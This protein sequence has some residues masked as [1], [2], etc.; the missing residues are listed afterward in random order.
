M[1][2]KFLFFILYVLISQFISVSSSFATPATTNFQAYIA[3]PDGKPLQ[4]ANVNFTLKYTNPT[5][6]CVL[7]AEEFLNRNMQGSSGNVNLRMGEGNIVY[8]G[9]STFYNVFNNAATGINC[10]DGAVSY[11]P[12]LTDIRKLTVIF[13]HPKSNGD[14][15][16]GGIEIES[17]PF[18]MYAGQA[19]TALN[20][21]NFS[22]LL[23]GDITGIQN[24]TSVVK[25]RGVPV[26][27][28]APALG[29]VLQFNGTQYVPVAIPSAPVTSVAGRTGAVVL[30]N[31]DISGLGDAAVKN[32]GTAAGTLAAGNDSRIT[33]AF[34]TASTLAGDL[35]GNLPN[36]TVATVNGKTAAQVAIS[37]DDTIAATNINTVGT[38][39]KR[40]GSGN[41]AVGNITGNNITSTNSSATTFS[42]RNLFL[43]DNTNTNK[44]TLKAPNVF[45]SDY[46]FILPV[47]AGTAGYVLSTDGAGNTNWIVASS[48]SV[49]N[50]T[51]TAPIAST[52]GAAP[53]ISIAT[54]NTST[55]GALTSADWNTFSA[56]QPQG[57][58]ITA[59]TGEVT[60]AGPGS[61]AATIA[62]N[63]VTTGKINNLAVTDA[64]INDVA[65][66]KITAVPSSTTSTTG[67]LSSTDWNTFNNKVG[68]AYT[69]AGDVTGTPAATTIAN[70]ARSKIAAGT[71][72]HVLINDAAG[73]IISEAQLAVSRGGT[74]LSSFTA[75]ALLMANVSGTAITSATC[76]AGQIL[77]WNGTTWTCV[78]KPTTSSG[79]TVTNVTST[80]SYLSVATGSTTPSLTVNVGS[81]A[82]T[83]AA[84]DDARFTDARTPNGSAGGDLTGTYPNPTLATSGV[85]AGTYSNIT[86]DAKG[87]LTGAAALTAGDITTALAYTPLNKTGDTMSGALA[88]GGN[89]ITGTGDIIMNTNQSFGL[90]RLT[91]IEQTTLTGLLNTTT[92]KG[93]T[94]FNT[95]TNNIRSDLKGIWNVTSKLSETILFN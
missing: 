16:I 92:D 56:K 66:S 70:L 45:A 87:R 63:A 34:Q 82:N 83:L 7:Y 53:V 69:L 39:V 37:V 12:S 79:G 38:I 88:M 77:E 54:A 32:T 18:A 29:H 28:T 23:S 46:N 10:E 62:A 42:G 24:L 20:T 31:T 25:I 76:A 64:K 43:Y 94:W 17:V 51:A 30:S 78:V 52:G 6:D 4:E 86:V 91:T 9:A 75:N 22:G 21:T 59:L 61:V 93:R 49:T 47:T 55:T 19:D 26:S 44:I 74:G 58:Y 72:N 15:T 27:A 48:G 41:I 14:Q 36:P 73:A 65:F 33:G 60:A 67:V 89:N 90:G 71:I 3:K 8:N 40:D 80:N 11:I 1:N 2:S 35:S 81:V 57:N 95:N 84:G 5:G 85:T 68:T 13:S 50:V